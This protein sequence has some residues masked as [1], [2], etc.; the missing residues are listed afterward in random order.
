MSEV[1]DILLHVDLPKRVAAKFNLPAPN[2][3]VKIQ[4]I[5]T[6]SNSP[7]QIPHADFASGKG[8]NVLIHLS[9][10]R[11][12]EICKFA[13][14]D[15]NEPEESSKMDLNP[16]PSQAWKHCLLKTLSPLLHWEESLYPFDSPTASAGSI[17]IFESNRI[18]RGPGSDDRERHVLYF[19]IFPSDYHYP[20]PKTV[21]FNPW[22][23]AQAIYGHTSPLFL[24]QLLLWFKENPLE[25]F[26]DPLLKAQIQS[27]LKK[28]VAKNSPKPKKRRRLQ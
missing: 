28:F 4:Y 5:L 23:V 6:P 27:A 20:F 13:N 19:F 18:H 17:Q 8:F 10:Q 3:H 1:T 14:F 26:H 25:H 12:T 7:P 22:T 16:V 15:P 11:A 21:Q 2:H 9:E 24:T